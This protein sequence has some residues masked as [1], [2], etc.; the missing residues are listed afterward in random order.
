MRALRCAIYRHASKLRDGGFIR[1]SCFIRV[2]Y[3]LR[4]QCLANNGIQSIGYEAAARRNSY[5]RISAYRWPLCAAR[6]SYIAVQK[7]REIR[8]KIT[9]L[10]YSRR[11]TKAGASAPWREE[12]AAL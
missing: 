9:F 8:K 10:P 5:A 2:R 11:L 1:R 6:R 4:L 3:L 12:I 7:C